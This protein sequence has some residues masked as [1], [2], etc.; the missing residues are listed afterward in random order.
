MYDKRL[1]YFRKD[2]FSKED[3]LMSGISTAAMGHLL[4]GSPCIGFISGNECLKKPTHGENMISL[5]DIADI[6]KKGD[7]VEIRSTIDNH[8]S[9][10]L[11]LFL[12]NMGTTDLYFATPPIRINQFYYIHK[13]PL[14]YDTS[15]NSNLS[16]T[17][18][19]ESY[20][21]D[22][23]EL[24]ALIYEQLKSNR[25]INYTFHDIKKSNVSGIES[26]LRKIIKVFSKEYPSRLSYHKYSTVNRV[27]IDTMS[28]SFYNL[29]DVIPIFDYKKAKGV[30]MDITLTNSEIKL[31]KIMM[32]GYSSLFRFIFGK[33][34]ENIF[35]LDGAAIHRPHSQSVDSV[36][37]YICEL[38][39]NECPRDKKICKKTAKKDK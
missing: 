30:G 21:K 34:R 7:E 39:K 4:I 18:G 36:I 13:P 28:I 5:K 10:I 24:P 33:Y 14:I 17:G 15:S 1:E 3:P 23:E 20:I 32:K 38:L 35:T 16:I 25:F 27:L 37:K 12:F 8:L 26:N 2:Y 9:H 19:L 6:I 31:N 11:M 29:V 22:V